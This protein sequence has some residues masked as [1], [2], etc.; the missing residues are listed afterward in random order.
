MIVGE[1]H[2]F[3]IEFS[4]TVRPILGKIGLWFVGRSIHG[5]GSDYLS[6]ISDFWRVIVWPHEFVNFPY[7]NFS[8]D[9]I[10][11]RVV[12]EK[13]NS[14]EIRKY[15]I[16]CSGGFEYCLFI[17]YILE[18]NVHVVWSVDRHHQQGVRSP[19]V[20]Y[21]VIPFVVYRD[22]LTE[23]AKKNPLVNFPKVSS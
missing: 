21:A 4:P 15:C 1:T 2:Q 9:Q 8:H 19:I 16:D 17:C 12:S 6:Y 5:D 3:A 10:H 20:N 13:G 14:K 23:F 18:G 7:Y 11:E 22:T